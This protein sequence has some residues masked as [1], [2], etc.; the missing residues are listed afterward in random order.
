MV[1]SFDELS[2]LI[3]YFIIG[4]STGIVLGFTVW[5]SRMIINLFKKFF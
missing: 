3:Q 4:S 1:D 5:C 2:Y